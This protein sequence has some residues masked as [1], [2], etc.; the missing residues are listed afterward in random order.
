M[1][2]SDLG[3]E[4]FGFSRYSIMSSA[5]RKSLTSSLPI[6]MLVSFCRLIA[7]ARTFN[8]MLSSSGESGDI[9]CFKI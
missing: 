7:E 4:S 6:L 1:S 5:K 2:S 9:L 8:T 3:V